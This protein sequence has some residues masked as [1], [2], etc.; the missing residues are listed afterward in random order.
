MW[1]SVRLHWLTTWPRAA[2][3]CPH[4]QILAPGDKLE[5]ELL[6][7]ESIIQA[8]SSS[9]PMRCCDD[10]LPADCLAPL[11]HWRRPDPV[12]GVSSWDM[13]PLL[14][15]DFWLPLQFL[16]WLALL[17]NP[18]EP[19]VGCAGAACSSSGGGKRHSTRSGRVAGMCEFFGVPAEFEACTSE[20]GAFTEEPRG[21]A[22]SWRTMAGS[23]A[24]AL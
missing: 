14:V 5:P 15:Q 6:L 19:F 13:E 4:C 20:S 12:D 10:S 24:T 23:A 16:A 8:I 21:L 2:L 3:C 11:L 1:P 17:F 9:Q 22:F 18:L 7:L